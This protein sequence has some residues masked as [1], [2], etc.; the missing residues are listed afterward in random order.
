[1]DEDIVHTRRNTLEQYEQGIRTGRCGWITSFL[2]V[3]DFT[4]PMIISPHYWLESV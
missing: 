2:G 4:S 3:K 1:M